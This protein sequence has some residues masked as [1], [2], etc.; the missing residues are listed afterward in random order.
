MIRSKFF[1]RKISLHEVSIPT[2]TQESN[3]FIQGH[4][5]GSADW[6]PNIQAS[7]SGPHTIDPPVYD[8]D[9]LKFAFSG[10]PRRQTKSAR[11]LASR[12][13]PN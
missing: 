1:V 12:D 8:P 7:G 9:F 4:V 11:T 6:D 2:T 13:S 5:K 10:R 3:K